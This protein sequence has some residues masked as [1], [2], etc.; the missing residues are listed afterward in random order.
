[1]SF[2]INTRRGLVIGAGFAKSLGNVV[3]VIHKIV[4]GTDQPPFGREELILSLYAHLGSVSSNACLGCRVGPL[5]EIGKVGRTGNKKNSAHL[6][7]EIRRQSFVD[8]DG[9]TVTL[10][11]DPR[12]N[13]ATWPASVSPADRGRSF[14][15]QNY[16]APSTFVRRGVCAE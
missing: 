14:I 7:W 11:K 4:Y 6:H 3:L 12:F 16:C 10:K 13:P 1:M 9:E 15:A 2:S 5:D 8:T